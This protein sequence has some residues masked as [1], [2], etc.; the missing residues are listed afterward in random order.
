MF[1]QLTNEQIV[2]AAGAEYQRV[3]AA[4]GTPMNALNSVVQAGAAAGVSK[5]EIVGAF[6]ATGNIAALEAVYAQAVGAPVVS[7]AAAVNANTQ[8]VSGVITVYNQGGAPAVVAQMLMKNITIEQ[9]SAAVSASGIQ[10]DP[11]AANAIINTYRAIED[12]S[13]RISAASNVQSVRGDFERRYWIVQTYAQGAVHVP[14]DGASMPPAPPVASAPAPAPMVRT[15]WTDADIVQGA[16]AIYA[17]AGGGDAG[18]AAVGRQ[19]AEASPYIPPERT[20]RAF[21]NIGG[22]LWANFVREAR[23]YPTTGFAQQV[24][25]VAGPVPAPPPPAAVPALTDADIVQGARAIYAA[26]GGLQNPIVAYNAVIS[27]GRSRQLSDANIRDA[28]QSTGNIVEWGNAIAAAGRA[29]VLAIPT[30]DPILPPSIS[31]PADVPSGPVPRPALTGPQIVQAIS[32]VFRTQPDRASGL[33]AARAQAAAN[34]IPWDDVIASFREVGGQAWSDFQAAEGTVT[35]RVDIDRFPRATAP[36]APAVVQPGTP[37]RLTGPQI[38][39]AIS[40]VFRTQPDAASGLNAARAQAQAY[41]VPWSDVVAAFQ[42]EGGA[43]LASFA[44]A[45]GL[46]P[47]LETTRATTAPPDGGVP[48]WVIPAVFALLSALGR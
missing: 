32:A 37:L 16:R 9:L 25:S 1:G 18:W 12:Q 47:R 43:A 31:H 39:Q 30:I 8:L 17:A 3:I 5:A 11:T 44:A 46:A 26:A 41:G 15:P 21:L 2:Q 45:G 33:N 36:T 7:I 35:V 10:V 29:S 6:Q 48:G 40:G 34:N 13:R 23:R 19:G 4:G 14:M 20:I 22:E 42:V 27:A 24:I 28:F 38:V